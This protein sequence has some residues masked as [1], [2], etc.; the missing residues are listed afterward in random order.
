MDE[1]STFE[2]AFCELDYITEHLQSIY[3]SPYVDDLNSYLLVA[4]RKMLDSWQSIHILCDNTIDTS[5]LITLSR[6]II[7]NYTVLHFIHI[8]SKML[9]ERK[10][11]H[12]LYILDGL[13]NR[14][15]NLKKFPSIT[16]DQN[17]IE[18]TEIDELNRKINT[19]IQNDLISKDRLLL[20][21]RESPLYNINMEDNIVKCCNWRYKKLDNTIKNNRF[22]WSELYKL[23]GIKESVSYFISGYMSEFVHGLCMSNIA[24]N[25][26]PFKKGQILDINTVFVNNTINLIKKL[27]ETDLNKN[28]IDIKKSNIP[29]FCLLMA[30]PEYISSIFSK[31]N[32]N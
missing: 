1:E 3:N 13:Q 22:S 16:F 30:T 23:T 24:Y 25:T 8:S 15:N 2:L 12:Y 26:A 19:T 29:L 32:K 20:K 4:I 27:F 21:I 11:R 7:D 31:A 17:Y 10:L 6:M 9:E 28:D 14:L 5:S 18:Q